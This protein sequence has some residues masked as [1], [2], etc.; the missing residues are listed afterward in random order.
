LSRRRR[1]AA[2]AAWSPERRARQAAAIRASQ[3]WRKS[4]GPRTAEGKARSSA[5]ALKH[6][7]RSRASIE[8]RRE[9]RRILECSAGN[10][11]IAKH[12]LATLRDPA[13]ARENACQIPALRTSRKR[14]A[15]GFRHLGM[16][17]RNVFGGV[18]GNSA[19]PKV[20]TGQQACHDGRYSHRRVRCLSLR[21]RS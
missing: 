17:A 9:D 1:G 2:K 18:G 13:I 19:A 6:G 4:T 3:P 20:M 21:V 10:L 5:N 8:R 11:A 16:I 7:N 14:A 15:L 12:V